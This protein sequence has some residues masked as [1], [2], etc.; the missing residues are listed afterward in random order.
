MTKDFLFSGSSLCSL[1][2]LL[3][4]SWFV[5]VVSFSTWLWWRLLTALTC[6]YDFPALPYASDCL[7]PYYVWKNRMIHFSYCLLGCCFLF[8]CLFSHNTSCILHSG[9]NFCLVDFRLFFPI[10]PNLYPQDHIFR[11]LLLY[12][13]GTLLGLIMNQVQ[14]AEQAWS[15]A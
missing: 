14:G 8:L 7:H 15:C 10:M 13:L 11:L 2:L 4:S 1:L 5:K 12:I 3:V 9:R 6:L